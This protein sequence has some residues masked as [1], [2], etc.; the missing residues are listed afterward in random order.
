MNIV[1]LGAGL[2]GKEAVR[3]LIQNERVSTVYLA[4]LHT[5]EA[6][7]FV[8]TLKTDR[9]L[10]KQVDAQDEQAL[11]SLIQQGDI[12]VNALFYTFNETVARIAIAVGTHY[13]D[14][15]GH[16][17]GAT[18]KVLAMHEEAV[19]QG[20]TVVPDLGVAPGMMN[21]LA[22]Y[23]AEQLDEI[24]SIRIFVG[25]V[26]AHP[27]PPLQY[28]VVFSLDGVF[29]HYTEPSTI[30]RNGRLQTLPSLSEVE[31]VRFEQ[32]GSF[33]AFHTSGG[34]STL[35]ETFAQIDT[36]EYKTVR[37]HGHAEKFQL[38]IDLGLLNKE[39]M[40]EIDQQNIAVRDVMRQHFSD[41]LALGDEE[42]L[43]LLKVLVSGQKNERT[44]TYTYECIAKKDV[45]RQITAMARV[46]ASTISIVAQMIGEGAIQKKGA[47][48]PEKIVPGKAYIEALRNRDLHVIEQQM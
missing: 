40:V 35:P 5:E 4:D 21:I 30:I 2:M 37:Y 9:V 7:Q 33:E 13:V 28:A 17:G 31:E 36:L 48:P 38:L 12:V 25:G 18:K 11:T 23:G 10:I 14:L 42:D 8:A 20:V 34:T 41:L 1:V 15:G 32:L 46:T 29:D 24:S 47:W 39:C 22:G 19:A 16:I 3:D 45:E 27:K 26:P 44:Q 6:E 43:V